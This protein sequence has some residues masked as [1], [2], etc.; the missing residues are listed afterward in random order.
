MNAPDF[1]GKTA[2]LAV[3]VGQ[4]ESQVRDL[5][6]TLKQYSNAHRDLDELCGP[7]FVH[8]DGTVGDSDAVFQFSWDDTFGGFSWLGVFV[9]GQFIESDLLAHEVEK[10]ADRLIAAWEKSEREAHESHM[11]SLRRSA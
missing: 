10:T 9:A 11:D 4:L 8:L 3:K 2:E 7:G 1:L 5:Q 6:A